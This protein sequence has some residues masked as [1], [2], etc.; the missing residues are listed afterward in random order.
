MKLILTLLLPCLCLMSTSARGTDVFYNNQYGQSPNKRYK[1]SAESP[2]NQPGKKRTAF[3]EDFIIK[4][5]DAKS[6]K[7]LW[8]WEQKEF[9]PTPILVFPADNGCLVMLDSIY[10]L[11][12]FDQTGKIQ[13]VCNF[14]RDISKKESEK[15]VGWSTAGPDVIQYSQNGFLTYKGRIYF[16]IRLFWGK[17]FIVDVASSKL[18]TGAAVTDYFEQYL[19]QK[20]R[21]FIQEFDGEYYRMHG[22]GSKHLKSE[23]IDAVFVIKQHNISEGYWLINATLDRADDGRNDSSLK[24]D[25]DKVESNIFMRSKKPLFYCACFALSFTVLIVLWYGLRGS[26]KRKNE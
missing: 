14:L 15:Y 26:K 22:C 18:E 1:A 24:S 21:K 7:V 6:D 16:Y 17:M 9:D 2:A 13:Q 5:K 12:V 19:V 11:Y 23:L 20:T 10:T 25:L 4:F 3:Q 8:E